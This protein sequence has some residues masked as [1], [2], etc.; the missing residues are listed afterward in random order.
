MSR[1]HYFAFG[2]NMSSARFLARIPA[3]ESVGRGVLSGWRFACN[4]RGT[5]G[6]AKA[7]IVRAEGE[8]VWGVIYRMPELAL[9]RLDRIEGG[10][11]RIRVEV[12]LGDAPLPCVCYASTRHTDH[13]VPFD[14]YK[15]HIIAGAEEFGLPADYV[16]TLRALPQRSPSDR[17]C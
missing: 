5:D 17:L 15:E 7:N 8:R 10:Y 12:R 11:E 9:S 2:S 4:K 3:A 13:R 1:V 14:W 16:A 6:S